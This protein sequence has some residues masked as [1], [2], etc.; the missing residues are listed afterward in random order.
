MILFCHN[1]GTKGIETAAF[2]GNCGTKLRKVKTNVVA[3]NTPK[4]PPKPDKVRK[5]DIRS[6]RIKE[7]D[8]QPPKPD[9]VRTDDI[10]SGF[11]KDRHVN[12]AKQNDHDKIRREQDKHFEQSHKKTWEEKKS[13]SKSNYSNRSNKP[14]NR[15][16]KSKP[17]PIAP[18]IILGLLIL[19]GVFLFSGLNQEPVSNEPVSNEPK[20]VPDVVNWIPDGKQ[21]VNGKLCVFQTFDYKTSMNSCEWMSADLLNKNEISTNTIK[22]Q[23]YALEYLN[24]RRNSPCSLQFMQLD[25]PEIQ[26]DCDSR[27]TLIMSN[28]DSAQKKS[29]N[30]ASVCGASSHWDTNGF[31]PYMTYSFNGG[32]GAINENIGGKFSLD[33]DPNAIFY[34]TEGNIQALIRENIDGMLYHDSHADWGHRES[35]LDPLANKVSFGISVTESCASFVVHMEKDYITWSQFPTII[36]SGENQQ[37]SFSGTID[38]NFCNENVCIEIINEESFRYVMVLAYEDAPP[39]DNSHIIDMIK[40]DATPLGY[41]IG[42]SC[43]ISSCNFSPGLCLEM[44]CVEPPCDPAIFICPPVS[45]GHTAANEWQVNCNSTKC[46]FSINTNLHKNEGLVTIIFTEFMLLTLDLG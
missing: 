18:L 15:N 35:L 39:I 36:T 24:Q 40:R 8:R 38:R 10:R 41:S 45:P 26:R 16:T 19:G 37:I 32:R 2:C 13:F 5:D 23:A 31:K 21:S 33:D 44:R 1:C 3:P 25:N 43:T 14:R 12:K 34:W 6:K 7:L 42:S 27:G 29:D 20:D 30:I 28:I 9:K 4:I 22:M 17:F 46:S 11:W